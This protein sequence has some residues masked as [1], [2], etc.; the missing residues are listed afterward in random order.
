MGRKI[1]VPHIS[2][3]AVLSINRSSDKYTGKA[4]ETI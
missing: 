2:L 3:R 4:D 1:L